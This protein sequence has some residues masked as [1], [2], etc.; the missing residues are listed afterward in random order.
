[1]NSSVQPNLNNNAFAF[2]NYSSFAYIFPHDFKLDI[3]I[4][5][6]YQAA[7]GVYAKP[8]HN[9]YVNSYVSKKFL[10]DKSLETRLSVNDLLNER[11]GIN[12]S[13]EGTRFTE[14]QNNV[15]NRFFMFKVVYNFTSMKGEYKMKVKFLFF[16]SLFC[17]LAA[18]YAQAQY[19][20]F[21]E[22]GTITYERT[23]YLHNNIKKM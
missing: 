18:P 23:F 16:I 1:M 7:T 12:R 9:M 8:I 3:E 22:N 10:K 19:A 2:N 17:V 20:Y 14:T 21:P 5:Q 11:N 13:Q 6:N 15:I 4:N